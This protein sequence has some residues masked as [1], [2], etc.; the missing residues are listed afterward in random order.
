MSHRSLCIKVRKIHGEKALILAKKLGIIN[1]KLKILQSLNH[2]CI[3]LLRSPNEVELAKL[4][5]QVPDLEY[6]NSL[7]IEKDSKRETLS[8]ILKDQLPSSMLSILPRALDII[9]DIA[10][11]EIPLE[12]R[13]HKQIIGQ[14]ILETHQNLKT[15][16]AKIGAISGIYRLRELDLIAGER[17]TTTIH[18]E[19]GCKYQVDI[20]KAYFSPRL[21]HEHNRVA[22]VVQ[23]GET[24]IDLFSGVGPFSVL[25]AKKNIDAKIYAVD[26]NPKAVQFLKKNIRLNRVNNQVI[27]ILGN[28]STVVKDRL[29]GIADRVI[30]NLPEKALEFVDVA[31]KAV[32]SSGGIIHYYTFSRLPNSM[33]DVKLNFS[34][35]VKKAGR[36]VDIFL[37]AKT[38]RE[39]APYECQ[40]VLDA[41]IL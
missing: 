14:A 28:A 1:P 30:M 6:E 21:S 23:S 41:K 32:K 11:V 3:P 38:I 33:Q 16:F 36:Q 39:T 34:K 7:F 27:P 12:L 31:C 26:I 13:T 29:F 25:I 9:G 24:V 5:G 4:K 20:A 10:V 19:Y 2:I 35:M 40:I 17:R 15:V 8:E 18:K 22:S 37:F